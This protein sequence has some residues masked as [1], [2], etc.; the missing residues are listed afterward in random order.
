METIVERAFPDEGTASVR[1][2]TYERPGYTL[3]IRK[4]ASVIKHRKQSES[5]RDG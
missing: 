1:A 5:V 3:K 4:L 2:V